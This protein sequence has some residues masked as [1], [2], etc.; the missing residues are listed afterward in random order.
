MMKLRA[1]PVHSTESSRTLDETKTTPL[2]QQQ[3]RALQASIGG[4]GGGGDNESTTSAV[5]AQDQDSYEFMTPKEKDVETPSLNEN[6]DDNTSLLQ[7]KENA[8]DNENE[9]EQQ[10]QQQ[11]QQ[12][13]NKE[14]DA[15]EKDDIEAQ[16]Q[17]KEANND[18]KDSETMGND[19]NGG[20]KDELEEQDVVQE[21]TNGTNNKQDKEQDPEEDIDTAVD[22]FFFV[23]GANTNETHVNSTLAIVNTSSPTMETIVEIASANPDFSTLISLLTRADLIETLQ[24]EGP[25]TVFAPTNE[26]FAA[27]DEDTL[28]A[29]TSTDS[30]LLSNVLL[31]HV[32]K[33]NI[34]STNLDQEGTTVTTRNGD[35]LTVTSLNPLTINDDATVVAT[36]IMATNGVIHVIDAVLVP[37][38]DTDT[39]ITANNEEEDQK[40]QQENVDDGDGDED[41]DEQGD[42]DEEDGKEDD[43]LDE[44]QDEEMKEGMK[45]KH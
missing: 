38:I 22:T 17:D 11:Q 24:G 20:Q 36:D 5:A 23:G 3:R 7:A 10:Q 13:Q 43:K 34:S 6:A 12:Q 25:F 39:I 27:L 1:P 44:Q 14:Q 15:E 33:G 45:L 29:V 37:S 26:A 42:G 32:V 18:Q 41:E 9:E 28:Q 40:Q 35:T 30:N 2:L 16:E 4:G 21:Q 31:H 8:E 19:D